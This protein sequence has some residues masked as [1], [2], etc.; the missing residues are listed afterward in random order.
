ML[1][2]LEFDNLAVYAASIGIWKPIEIEWVGEFTNAGS[3][4]WVAHGAWSTWDFYPEDPERAVVRHVIGLPANGELEE[5]L[6]SLRHELEHARQVEEIGGIEFESSYCDIAY[7]ALE[8]GKGEY[9]DNPY[10]IEAN[11]VMETEWQDLL[12]CVKGAA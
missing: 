2:K 7:D 10:E 4:G 12:P 11:H 1:M 3:H 6:R 8:D 9:R 5:T